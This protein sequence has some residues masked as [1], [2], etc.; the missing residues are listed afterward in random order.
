MYIDPIVSYRQG[1]LVKGEGGL[2]PY[3][4]TFMIDLSQVSIALRNATARSLI[5]LDEFGNGTTPA[6]YYNSCSS[7]PGL[8][9]RLAGSLTVFSGPSY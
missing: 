6:G 7:D 8:D 5:L 3:P 1:T 9:F 4:R 2:N